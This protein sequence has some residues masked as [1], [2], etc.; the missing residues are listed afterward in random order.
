MDINQNEEAFVSKFKKDA[1]FNAYFKTVTFDNNVTKV[2]ESVIFTIKLTLQDIFKTVNKD[3]LIEAIAV[4][5]SDKNV[6]A[7]WID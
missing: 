4:S 6:K 1:E 2:N 7:K 5:D 3:F